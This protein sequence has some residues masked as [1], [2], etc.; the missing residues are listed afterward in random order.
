MMHH[1]DRFN[2]IVRAVL[3]LAIIGLFALVLVTVVD[4]QGKGEGPVANVLLG[5]LTAAVSGIL[6]FYFGQAVREGR[7]PTGTPADP[8]STTVEN[9]PDTPVPVVRAEEAPRFTDPSTTG[10]PPPGRPSSTA[11]DS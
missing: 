1:A 9:A 2:A 11:A 8:I 7:D 10:A 6:G 3:A 4:G 5:A